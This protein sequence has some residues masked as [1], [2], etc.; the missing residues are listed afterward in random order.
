VTDVPLPRITHAASLTGHAVDA[1]LAHLADVAKPLRNV[2]LH[3][4]ADVDSIGISIDLP[5]DAYLARR[6]A[7][8]ANA[9]SASPALASVAM[10]RKGSMRAE[11]G[12]GR[13]GRPARGL[14]G[15]F[16]ALTITG[17]STLARDLAAADAAGIPAP[18]RDALADRL[19]LLTGDDDPTRERTVRT[20]VYSG[21]DAHHTTIE[22]GTVA[23]PDLL[24]RVASNPSL[25]DLDADTLR[26]F[27]AVHGSLAIS[28]TPWVRVAATSTGLAPGFTVSYA[29]LTLDDT[30]ALAGQFS[31]AGV[32]RMRPFLDGLLVK[33]VTS[34][35]IAFGA[36]ELGPLWLTVR[37]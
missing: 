4:N 22:L 19:R 8:L 34:I 26:T 25:V 5:D 11:R 13:Q 17:P 3:T 36:R 7:N 30:L 27:R 14:A 9:I 10:S 16:S 35:D 32:Q 15:V 21:P 31:D 6:T 33:T 20:L 18:I 2:A 23:A 29:G 28:P 37:L 24:A 1:L 12:I